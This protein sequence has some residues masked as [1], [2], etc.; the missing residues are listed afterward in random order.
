MDFVHYDL[1]QLKPGQTVEVALSGQANVLLLD[2][3]N[4]DAYRSG[5]QYSYFGGWVTQTPYRIGLPRAAHWHIVVDLGG[6]AGSIRSA[7]R[8]LGG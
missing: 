7:V 6:A 4:F 2:T 5:G 1:G 3:M 8:V